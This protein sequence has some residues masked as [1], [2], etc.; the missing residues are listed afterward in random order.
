MKDSR[1]IPYLLRPF[2]M[3]PSHIDAHFPDV[4]HFLSLEP[5]KIGLDG[6]ARILE[7]SSGEVN[8]I[9]QL[10]ASNQ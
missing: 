7:V 8:R 6:G 10:H 1:G 9:L 3:C 2:T 4:G 5:V